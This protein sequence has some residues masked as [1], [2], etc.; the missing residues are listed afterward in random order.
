MAPPR[1]SRTLERYQSACHG[2][3][4]RSSNDSTTIIFPSNRPDWTVPAAAA[5]NN[6]PSNERPLRIDRRTVRVPEL[7]PDREV[8]ILGHLVPVVGLGGEVA[9]VV[10]GGPCRRAGAARGSAS[11]PGPNMATSPTTDSR[12]ILAPAAAPERT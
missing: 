4:S 5:A 1:C 9:A 8:A 11:P 2:S 10:D 12:P 7:V 3:A 6:G